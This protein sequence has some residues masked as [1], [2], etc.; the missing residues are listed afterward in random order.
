M[1]IYHK[2]GARTLSWRVLYY[3]DYCLV[4]M[5][6]TNGKRNPQHVDTWRAEVIMRHSS[7]TSPPWNTHG[8]SLNLKLKD[9]SRL[10]EQWAPR[11]SSYCFPSRGFTS[12]VWF[13]TECW[14]PEL[15]PASTSVWKPSPQPLAKHILPKYFLYKASREARRRHCCYCLPGLPNAWHLNATYWFSPDSNSFSNKINVKN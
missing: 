11:T 5:G 15:S 8:L 1:I 2:L 10:A 13:F 3:S 4:S 9:L 12:T 7:I 6:H 14:G